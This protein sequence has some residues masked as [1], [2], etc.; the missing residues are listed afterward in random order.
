MNNSNTNVM[1]NALSRLT[2]RLVSVIRDKYK[3]IALANIF[4]NKGG[5][6]V[7]LQITIFM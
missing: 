6:F 2:K 5:F 7:D 1:L 3:I 4:T